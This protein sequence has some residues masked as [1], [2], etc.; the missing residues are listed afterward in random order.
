MVTSKK[1][2]KDEKFKHF[3]KKVNPYK[4]N[5]E[6]KEYIVYNETKSPIIYDKYG[7]PIK[8]ELKCPGSVK[9]Y[10][11]TYKIGPIVVK[12]KPGILTRISLNLIKNFNI[13]EFEWFFTEN[14][15]FDKNI[16]KMDSDG[17]LIKNS[18][19]T[20][21]SYYLNN[22]NNLR[23]EVKN[24]V[25]CINKFNLD[26]SDL[27]KNINEKEFNLHLRDDFKKY[28]ELKNDFFIDYNKNVK[29]G[30]FSDCD[31]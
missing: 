1:G 14:I 24:Q 8:G 11:D 21:K 20:L 23:N 10:L 3:C 26:N 13:N 18:E 22:F 30:D 25:E 19:E 2:D 17:I 27:I 29:D 16:I 4:N 12:E 15:F 5:S 6:I 31:D 28:L 9:N 7:Y